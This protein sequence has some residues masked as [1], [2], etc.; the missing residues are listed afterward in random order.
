MH[1]AT[2]GCRLGPL[3]LQH[4]DS[5][6]LAAHSFSLRQQASIFTAWHARGYVS[7]HAVIVLCQ[8]ALDGGDEST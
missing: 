3:L 4:E 7:L 6:S 5:V 1:I 8:P 2:R